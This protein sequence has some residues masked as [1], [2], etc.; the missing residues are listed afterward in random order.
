M[1]VEQREV[2]ETA[3]RHIEQLVILL[4]RKGLS[5]EDALAIVRGVPKIEERAA[6]ETAGT[7]YED[8]FE[9]PVRSQR[10]SFDK[11][12]PAF[13]HPPEHR[14]F[15]PNVTTPSVFNAQMAQA[16]TPYVLAIA[17]RVAEER[18]LEKPDERVI[19]RVLRK[20]NWSKAAF[21][22]KGMAPR[23]PK[24][25]TIKF[26]DKW[27]FDPVDRAVEGLYIKRV[28]PVM[29]GVMT[30]I[31]LYTAL[32]THIHQLRAPAQWL[33]QK[34]AK[35]LQASGKRR[36]L[37]AI[38]SPKNRAAILKGVTRAARWV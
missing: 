24:S 8:L 7:L 13:H 34:S 2:L 11:E 5:E 19:K 25:K 17:N 26:L 33:A 35:N 38:R 10:M 14:E 28:W 18:G 21:E 32:A 3:R 20:V 36:F 16:S 27:I 4:R 23:P 6:Y 22:M 30:P 31:L 12:D 37:R 9:A 29:T 15:M 1:H